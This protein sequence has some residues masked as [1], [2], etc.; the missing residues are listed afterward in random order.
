MVGKNTRKVKVHV[1]RSGSPTANRSQVTS[2]YQCLR[3]SKCVRYARSPGH[4]VP[5]LKREANRAG[6]DLCPRRFRRANCALRCRGAGLAD[7]R[8]CSSSREARA[9]EARL[10]ASPGRREERTQGGGPGQ[11]GGLTWSCW[12]RPAAATASRAAT[13]TFLQRLR[14]P[15][16]PPS[17]RLPK[18]P[19]PGGQFNPAE[20]RPTPREPPSS[21]PPP[22]PRAASPVQSEEV[23]ESQ[24]AEDCKRPVTNQPLYPGPGSKLQH[25]ALLPRGSSVSE[26]AV[27]ASVC[28]QEQV[29]KQ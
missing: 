26:C 16:R 2:S 5:G 28:I 15:P 9:T 7:A 12:L 13:S 11:L 6:E 14:V 21:L 20:L 25:L 17:P 22:G 23:K 8:V 3:G 1:C 19:P 29:S 10:G 18:P 24:R 27:D 4:C